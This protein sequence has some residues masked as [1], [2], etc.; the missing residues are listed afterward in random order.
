MPLYT[1]QQVRQ[2][3]VGGALALWRSLFGQHHSY[4]RL[5][6]V[7]FKVLKFKHRVHVHSI[8][9]YTMLDNSGLQVARSYSVSLRPVLWSETSCL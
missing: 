3:W 2:H 9:I 5:T 7:E 8:Y 1:L 6:L 4:L